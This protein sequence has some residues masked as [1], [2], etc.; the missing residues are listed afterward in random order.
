MRFSVV[1]ARSLRPS[2]GTAAA[3]AWLARVAAEPVP[4]PAERIAVP[5]TVLWPGHDPLFPP[6]GPTGSAGS[7]PT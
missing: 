5:T 7:S 2:A 1:I 6:A 3:P 4:A